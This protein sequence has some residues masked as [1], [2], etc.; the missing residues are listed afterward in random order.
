MSLTKDYV[1]QVSQ[2]FADAAVGTCMSIQE[3]LCFIDEPDFDDLELDWQLI[4]DQ[5]FLCDTCGWWCE[6]GD[7]SEW[8]EGVCNECSPTYTC[9]D[10]GIEHNDYDESENCCCEED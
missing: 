3:V 8:D 7:W 4:E 6:A 9:Y 5:I 1:K 2:R 10:C